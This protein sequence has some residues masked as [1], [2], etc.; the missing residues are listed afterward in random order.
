[1]NSGAFVSDI[2]TNSVVGVVCWLFFETCMTSCL[3]SNR[4]M[5]NYLDAVASNVYMVII[6]DEYIRLFNLLIFNRLYLKLY[7]G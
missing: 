6:N 7:L 4:K 2:Y 5:Q 3:F 1:M